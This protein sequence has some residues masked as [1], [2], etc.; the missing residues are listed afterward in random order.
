MKEEPEDEEEGDEDNDYDE[1]GEERKNGKNSAA[2][3]QSREQRMAQRNGGQLPIKQDPSSPSK[4]PSVKKEAA[5]PPK[6]TKKP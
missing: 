6:S 2:N 1:D 5:S 4:K 3:K